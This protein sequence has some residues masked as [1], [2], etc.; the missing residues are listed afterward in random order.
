MNFTVIFYVGLAHFLLGYVL[1]DVITASLSLLTASIDR[2]H[3][4]VALKT[5]KAF[6]PLSGQGGARIEPGAPSSN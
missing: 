3:W 1:R 2:I 6:E 5:P 4:I